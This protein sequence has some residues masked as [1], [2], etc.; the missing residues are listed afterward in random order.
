MNV[1]YWILSSHENPKLTVREREHSQIRFTTNNIV[2]MLI[3]YPI[4]IYFVSH[5]FHLI[6]SI[7]DSEHAYLKF[8]S[9]RR[10]HKDECNKSKS[11]SSS[12]IVSYRI[13]HARWLLFFPFLFFSSTSFFA[14]LNIH[15][16]MKHTYIGCA[17][18]VLLLAD[19]VMDRLL[20]EIILIAEHVRIQ[21]IYM[22]MQ[23]NI[24]KNEKMMCFWLCII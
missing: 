18:N 10:L 20:I 21:S 7:R 1:K 13:I 6:G 16:R 14:K 5:L 11:S 15:I 12:S 4:M 9:F 8:N 19:I 22:W 2:D 24:Q 3:K 23:Y 17:L